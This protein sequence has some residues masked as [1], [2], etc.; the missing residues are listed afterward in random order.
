[1]FSLAFFTALLVASLAAS[2][3]ICI[4][5]V[6]RR[7]KN[8]LLIALFEDILEAESVARSSEEGSKTS[9]NMEALCEDVAYRFEALKASYRYPHYNLLDALKDLEV[10]LR[11]E[12]TKRFGLSG[13]ALRRRRTLLKQ[14][15]EH[16]TKNAAVYGVSLS[17]TDSLQTPAEVHKPFSRFGSF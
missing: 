4:K 10:L 3:V 8:K 5:L 14:V 13:G 12:G 15:R 16:I 6:S 17:A 11:A 2:S 1:M 7:R 9:V